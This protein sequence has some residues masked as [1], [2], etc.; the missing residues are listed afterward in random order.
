M[1]FLVILNIAVSVLMMLAFTVKIWR[2]RAPSRAAWLLVT[3]DAAV[4]VTLILLV[5]RWDMAGM[6]S[7]YILGGL[8]AIAIVASWRN[9]ARRPWREATSIFRTHWTTVLSLLLFSAALVYV[10]FGIVRTP[11][12]H[13]LAFPLQGG[14]F[15]VAQGGGIGLLNH[16]SGHRAQQYAA[17]I[18]AVG[19]AGFRAD[20]ILPDDPRRYAVFA[21]AVVAPCA[22]T[23]TAAVDGLP[24]LSPPEMDPDNAAGNHVVLA[25][26]GLS[27][28]LA[29]LRDGS[30]AVQPGDAVPAG[31][32]LGEV[33][34]SGNTTE[35][36]LHIHA[37]DLESGHGVPMSFDGAVPVRNRIYMR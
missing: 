30:V 22:G 12:P 5:A 23:V 13:S 32:P 34:N 25:C 7:R 27:V 21:A 14:R 3:A 6:Y 9:H 11:A 8:F 20:G 33:G 18:T 10:S 1:I 4:F 15:V 16:H 24:D 36:H 19:R 26:E 17:D 31:Q 28:E 29:H 37:V 35:P 2:L